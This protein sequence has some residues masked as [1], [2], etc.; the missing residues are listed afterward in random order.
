[1][2]RFYI[3]WNVSWLNILKCPLAEVCLVTYYMEFSKKRGIISTLRLRCLLLN[4]EQ[5]AIADK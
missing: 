3:F 5:A 1:M 4:V 2:E